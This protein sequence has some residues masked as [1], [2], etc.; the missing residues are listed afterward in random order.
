MLLKIGNLLML[1]RYSFLTNFKDSRKF[2]PKILHRI[3]YFQND[4]FFAVL[5]ENGI[6]DFAFRENS[7]SVVLLRIYISCIFAIKSEIELTFNL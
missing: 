3:R 6:I 4:I 2:N 1:A 5:A 7:T